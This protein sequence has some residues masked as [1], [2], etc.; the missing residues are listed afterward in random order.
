[1]GYDHEL[2]DRVRELVAGAAEGVAEQPMFGGLAFLIDGNMAVAASGRGGLLVRVNPAETDSLVDGDRVT[3][4]IMRRREMRGWLYVDAAAVATAGQ[5]ERWVA[6]GVT[7]ARSLPA[8]KKGQ[9]RRTTGPGRTE[10]SPL[11]K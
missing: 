1:M 8:K 6:R 11:Q 2:A 10:P 3:P 9:R 7:Y 4:M 5:L